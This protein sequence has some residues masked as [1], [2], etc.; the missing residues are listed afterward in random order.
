MNGMP[1]RVLAADQ[2]A[3]VTVHNENGPSSFVIVADKASN[4]I[5]RALGRLGVP[6]IGAISPGTSASAWTW[7]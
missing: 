2:P 5:P 4:S 6:E 3:P 7:A 1:D